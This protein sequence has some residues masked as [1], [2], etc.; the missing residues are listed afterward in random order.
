MKEWCLIHPWMT[1]FIIGFVVLCITSIVENI[2]TVINNKL[3][4]RQLEIESNKK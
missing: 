4:I 3:K 2:L 1:L